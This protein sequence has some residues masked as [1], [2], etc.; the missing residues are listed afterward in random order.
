[1]M[2]LPT[3]SESTLEVDTSPAPMAHR[4]L[5]IFCVILMAL[6]MA[7]FVGWRDARQSADTALGVAAHSALALGLLP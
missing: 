2:A 6:A 7:L 5:L 4:R 1:M 3:Q